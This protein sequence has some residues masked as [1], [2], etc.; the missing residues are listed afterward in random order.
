MDVYFLGTGAS[1]S[2][3]NRNPFCVVIKRKKE[4]IMLD[5]AEGAQF[6]LAKSKL[7][8]C[9]PMKIIVSHVHGDHILGLPGLLQSMKMFRRKT[10]LELFG[11]KKLRSFL[12]FHANFFKLNPNFEVTFLPISDGSIYSYDE[13][14]LNF[15]GVKHS[16]DCLGVVLLEKNRRG[17]FNG[18]KAQKLSIPNNLR[19][20][21]IKGETIT[22][23]GRII[24]PSDI[25][26]PPRKG[27]KIVYIPDTVFFEELIS[28]AQGSDL[29]IYNAPFSAKDLQHA[30]EK[31]HSTIQDVVKLAEETSTK[32]V[33]A[34]HISNRYATQEEYMKGLDSLPKKVIIAEDF[35]KV[36]IPYPEKGEPEIFLP[37]KKVK[38]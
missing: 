27:R 26:G 37:N 8:F 14:F 13:Y 32:L 16:I 28:I 23:G 20:L 4:L 1:A 6:L 34:T 33:V 7:G 9:K 3:G 2:L 22:W 12:L 30:E 5:P 15:F 17:K 24:K 21:L 31:S 18:E 35:L 38:L 19:P 36:H 25:I 10:Q 11:P 29:V